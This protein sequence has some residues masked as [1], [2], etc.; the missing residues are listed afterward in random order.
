MKLKNSYMV[1]A[2][3][4]LAVFGA[5]PVAGQERDRE[6]RRRERQLEAAEEALVA[7]QEA[8]NR[9]REARGEEAREQLEDAMRALRAAERE[10]GG[11]RFSVLSPSGVSVIADGLRGFTFLATRPRM[12]VEIASGSDV[13]SEAAGAEI[14]RVTPDSPADEAGLEAGDIITSVNGQ[15]LARTGRRGRE[16]GS[17]LIEVIREREAGDT[18]RVEYLRDG[19]TR[20]TSV[21]LRELDNEFSYA[22][23]GPGRDRLWDIEVPNVEVTPEIAV[24][25]RVLNRLFEFGWLNIELVTLNE[26][27]GEY[28]GTSE[29]L[30][31]LESPD[32]VAFDLRSGDV[33]L[34]IDGRKPTSPSHAMRII[35]SYDEGESF[36]FEIV[37]QRQRMTVSGVVP[38]RDPDMFLR[39]FRERRE[40]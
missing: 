23:S 4:G 3:L 7:L 36:E 18:V 37:R 9:L 2:L 21:V 40:R 5:G 27:L 20:T 29:G 30:L 33:I 13:A 39:Q 25:P 31:V 12:G 6:E 10:L 19:Q 34:S 28:F 8:V 24:R 17:K 15:N 26:E 14:L 16:P 32:D 35:R 22:I 38:E 1:A 11:A